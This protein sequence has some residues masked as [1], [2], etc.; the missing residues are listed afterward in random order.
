MLV[1]CTCMHVVKID[2]RR[3]TSTALGTKSYV[4]LDTPNSCRATEWP[5]WFGLLLPILAI[6]LF[7][8]IM[9]TIIIVSICK[10]MNSVSK[11][12]S[13]IGAKIDEKKFN[14]KNLM[15]AVVLSITFGLGWGVGFLAT[16]HE[17]TAVVI[18]FQGI[19]TVVVAFQ[20]VLIF[21][22]HGARSPEVQGLWKAMLLSLS[23][24]TRKVYSFTQSTSE[25]KS[26][27]QTMSSI[28]NSPSTDLLAAPS[29]VKS[30]ST[31]SVYSTDTM[32]TKIDFEPNPAYGDVKRKREV[33]D[34]IAT[35]Q[36]AAYETVKTDLSVEHAVY[37]TVN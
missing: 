8:W 15:I 13:E 10:H 5:F 3:L 32:D 19:F 18:V 29:T 31:F 27:K 30:P 6:Y 1:T 12:K 35:D 28:T 33:E 37:E 24:K 21:I 36:N 9:F 23:R 26:S 25:S 11:K 16:S 4:K 14:A 2:T 7:N 20:G 17:I 22:F 34:Y